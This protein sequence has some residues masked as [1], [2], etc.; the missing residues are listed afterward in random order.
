MSHNFIIRQGTIHDVDFILSLIKELA[1]HEKASHLVTA[2][3]ELLRQ[4]LF[5]DNPHAKTMIAE[6]NG[7]AIGYGIC[8]QHFSTYLGKYYI[9]IEDI[10]IKNDYRGKGYGQQFINYIVNLAQKRGQTRV[11]WSVLRDNKQAI[12]FYEKLGATALHERLIYRLST[13]N[14]ANKGK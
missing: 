11:E 10:Y 4:N 9:H 5:N 12:K 2:T 3:A 7:V 14:L 1:I 8:F 13:D 6:E